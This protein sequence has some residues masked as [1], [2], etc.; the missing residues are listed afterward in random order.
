MPRNEAYPEDSD[1]EINRGTLLGEHDTVFVAL[2]RQRL[3]ADGLLGGV[4]HP[5]IQ[6]I[7][8][9]LAKTADHKE[10]AGLIRGIGDIL[11]AGHHTLPVVDIYPLFG[12]N[13][14]KVGEWKTTGYYGFTHLEYAQKR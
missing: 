13:Q 11:Y 10:R 14:K 5:E 1:R 4:E 7:Y 3:A 12:V 2:L 9:R 6:N 8:A